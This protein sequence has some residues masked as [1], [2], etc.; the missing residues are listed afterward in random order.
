MYDLKDRTAVVTG[1]AGG[2]G[3]AIARRLAAE[4][5]AVAVLDANTDGAQETVS[6][7]REAGDAATAIGVDVTDPDSVERAFAEVARWRGDADVAPDIL[8]NN[9]GIITVSRVE[10]TRVEEWRKIFA[11]N[12]EGVFLCCRAAV[13]G[14]R[15]RG[16]GKIINIS[17]WFGKIGKPNYGA[18]SSSKA[19]VMGLT[20]SLAMEV[21]ADGVNV[22]A[23]CPGT[24]FETKLRDVADAMSRDLNLSTAEERAKAIPMGRVGKPDDVARVVTFLAGPESDYMTGQSVNITGGLLMH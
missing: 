18:Y 22:N 24:I 20:Q 12:V 2:I 16:S 8:V 15:A 17:S 3:R 21:A 4:G 23:V 10:D 13:P 6:L 9:A 1:S 11:V 5:A 19:A 14:M 7:I